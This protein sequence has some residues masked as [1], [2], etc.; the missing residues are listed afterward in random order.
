MPRIRRRR[1]DNRNRFKDKPDI[2]VGVKDFQITVINIF[3]EIED[4]MDKT[5]ERREHIPRD[6]EFL[7]LRIKWTF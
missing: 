7:F 1:P 3:K 6:L 5:D 4:K 2:R